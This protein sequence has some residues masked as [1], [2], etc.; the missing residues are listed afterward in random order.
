MSGVTVEFAVKDELTFV[1]K[2]KDGNVKEESESRNEVK[3]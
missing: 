2:D 3:Q 1:L